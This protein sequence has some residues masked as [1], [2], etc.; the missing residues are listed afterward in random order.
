MRGKVSEELHR[1]ETG[2]IF[3][4]GWRA[5][6]EMIQKRVLREKTG[7]RKGRMGREKKKDYEKR[8]LRGLEE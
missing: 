4:M 8:S 2:A 6:Q 7:R 1:K 3:K 5:F